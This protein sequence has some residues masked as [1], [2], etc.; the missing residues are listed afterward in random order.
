LEKEFILK[1]SDFNNVLLT[2]WKYV[3]WNY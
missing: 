3:M 1:L 2:R